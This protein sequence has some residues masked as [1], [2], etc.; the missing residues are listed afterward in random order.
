MNSPHAN[1]QHV[2]KLLIVD[3]D[4]SIVSQLRLAFRKEY[5]VFTAQNVDEAWALVQS[6]HPDLITLD[7]ALDGSNPETGFGVLEK[8][9]AFDPFMK[10]VLITG[11]D[12]EA[13]ARRAVEQ[14]AADFFGKPVDVDELRVL[15]RR[16]LAV[17]RLE[18][19]NAE[20][21]EHLDDE[22]RL[23]AI[24]GRSPGMQALFKRICKV[25]A[26]DNIEVLILGESGTGK[27]MVAKEIRRLSSRATKPFVT[28]DCTA[29]APTLLESELFGHV[30][31]TFT[32]AHE[33]RPGKLE[34]ADGGIVFLNEIGD[35]PLS[36][37]AKLLRF[38]QD[39][40]IERV[41]GRE[42]IKLDV[43]VIA[44]TNKDL[45]AEVRAGR[46]RQDLYY[47]LSGVELLMPPL[48]DRGDDILFLAQ[49]LMDRFA[50]EYGRGRKSLSVKAKQALVQQ[51]W[52]GNVRELQ[53]AIRGAV[54]L[55]S[56]RVLDVEDLGL[57]AAGAPQVPSL[58]EARDRA[59]REAIE[60]ALQLTGGNVS[61]A[62]GMLSI[63]RPSLHDRMTRLGI[64]AG[65]FRRRA[66]SNSV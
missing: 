58:K 2:A 29:I 6:E 26:V 11:N 33:S 18:R 20:V 5:Q 27:D 60:R 21:L 31:G 12:E 8:C 66:S 1:E 48:R 28:I 46:F 38:L 17:A 15:L 37:Q 14:G 50:K 9:I 41:G 44:A 47:R 16:Q 63:S 40:E 64:D 55:S 54:A 22:E 32:D 61:R 53:R 34:L 36:L 35:L 24:V 62:A 23:G 3:D 7:L 4:P 19:Q 65:D 45:E 25:S 43:R 13:N 51:Q 57:E 30:K 10:V 52:E 42:V 59:D 49:Y 56:G 39:H